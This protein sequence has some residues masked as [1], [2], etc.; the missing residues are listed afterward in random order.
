VN[1]FGFRFETGR[2]AD[3]AHLSLD[4]LQLALVEPEFLLADFDGAAQA[5]PPPPEVGVAL[6]PLLEGGLLLAQGEEV[7]YFAPDECLNTFRLA[8]RDDSTCA[9]SFTTDFSLV[10]QSPMYGREYARIRARG[11][12]AVRGAQGVITRC[13]MGA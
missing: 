1:L 11:Q 2:E 8:G 12:V 3:F 10:L 13:V 5:A 9:L 6:R 7:G 4:L